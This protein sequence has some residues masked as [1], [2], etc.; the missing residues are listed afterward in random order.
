MSSSPVEEST[1]VSV[2]SKEPSQPCPISSWGERLLLNPF[3]I[4]L[5][6]FAVLVLRSPD[7]L[8]FPELAFEDGNQMLAF[9]FNSPHPSSIFRFYNGYIQLLPNMIA[10]LAT[11]G[12]IT[13][14]PQL[15]TLGSM[16]LA[17]TGMFLV[18]RPQLAWLIPS[19]KDRAIAAL[20]L[21]LLPLGKSYVVY[22]VAYSLWSCLFLLVM[23]LGGPLPQ[24]KRALAVYSVAIILG[25]FSHP[26]SLV[27]FPILLLHLILDKRLPQRV[28]VGVF[29]A[30]IIA[31]QLF[32]V[33]HSQSVHATGS[34][35]HLAI[36]LFLSRVVF[37]TI[38][39]AMAGTTLIP[40]NAQF[41]HYSALAILGIVL[42]LTLS[43][44]IS[45]RA[46]CGVVIGLG[47][48]FGI[49]LAS[50]L[51][52]LATGPDFPHV[53]KFYLQRYFYVPKLLIAIFL[54]AQVIPRLRK[55]LSSLSIEAQ[56]PFLGACAIYLIGL[57]RSN[58]RLYA[59]V[60]EDGVK[61][62]AF[63][64]TVQQHQAFARADQE[65]TSQW[66]L[67]RQETNWDIQLNIDEHLGKR[68]R[69]SNASEGAK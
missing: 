17:A 1:E 68:G 65:Y 24:S 6:I 54:L 47:L 31:D 44:R 10:W 7:A 67:P 57:N 52:R 25:I 69:L 64:R 3:A 38:S 62:A 11:R 15:F 42:S 4:F 14:A 30:T 23:L 49:V 66:R 60:H 43:S 41:V 46:K 12:P 29:M 26:L 19:P 50:T 45:W 21:V 39:G 48:A 13:L 40:E 18:S 32:A 37:E 58:N 56:I 20:L 63:L 55:F 5:A 34:G 9:Y 53:F 16:T 22:N 27:V 59:N 51:A 8:R 36:K 2:S 28:C 33:E 61:I 35:V